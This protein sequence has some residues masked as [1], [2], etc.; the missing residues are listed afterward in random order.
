MKS[1]I[2]IFL[3][4]VLLFVMWQTRHGAVAHAI[5]E[6]TF[7]LDASPEI[8]VEREEVSPGPCLSIRTQRGTME[9]HFKYNTLEVEDPCNVM[10]DAARIFFTKY[11]KDG[12]DEYIARRLQ[13]KMK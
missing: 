6:N 10:N 3:I 12:A 11:F 2:I 5:G 9:I 8:E 1:L 4:G 13:G 7:T